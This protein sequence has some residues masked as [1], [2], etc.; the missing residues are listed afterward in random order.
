LY[1]FYI[2]R[3]YIESETARKIIFYTGV[4]FILIAIINPFFQDFI[5]SAQTATYVIGGLIL[6]GCVITYFKQRFTAHTDMPL[7][8]DILFWISL[9][10]LLFYIGYLPIKVLRFYYGLN[11]LEENAYLRPIHISLILT[12]YTC[13]IIGFLRMKKRLAK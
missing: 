13:F 10:L 7:K 12:M 9:G 11:N 6:I 1:F 3:Y 8:N 5:A 2:Y 4:F